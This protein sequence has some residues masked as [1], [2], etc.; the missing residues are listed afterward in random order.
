[1][2]QVSLEI[3]PGIHG[4]PR[5]YSKATGN[6]EKMENHVTYVGVRSDHI[7]GFL[8]ERSRVALEG[9]GNVKG[10]CEADQG[11]DLIDDGI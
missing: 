1:M 5:I 9:S 7:E 10:V 6:L 3:S 4:N 8:I 11:L 2:A